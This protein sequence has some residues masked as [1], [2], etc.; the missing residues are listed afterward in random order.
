MAYFAVDCLWSSSAKI[1][2]CLNDNLMIK[3]AQEHFLF[4]FFISLLL[5]CTI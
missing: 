4:L 5:G 3:V 2:L 1:K